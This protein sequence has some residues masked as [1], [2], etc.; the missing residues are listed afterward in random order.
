MS[1]FHF[2]SQSGASIPQ[3]SDSMSNDHVCGF[4]NGT[5]SPF[6][7][8]SSHFEP[9]LFNQGILDSLGRLKLVNLISGLVSK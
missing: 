8:G 4:A 6:L 1:H 3:I 2:I 7:E 9:V 5:C